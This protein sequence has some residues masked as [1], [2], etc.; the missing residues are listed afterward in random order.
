MNKTEKAEKMI[1][2]VRTFR[3]R[4]LCVPHAHDATENEALARWQSAEQGRPVKKRRPRWG[5][6]STFVGG[7]A[8]VE[9]DALRFVGV[10]AR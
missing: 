6:W 9:R 7:Y 10:L 8:L 5:W 4:N 2:A 1:K 3:L